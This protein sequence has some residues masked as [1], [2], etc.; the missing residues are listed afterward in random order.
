MQAKQD[1]GKQVRPPFRGSVHRVETRSYLS[2]CRS[3]GPCSMLLSL[4]TL[5]HSWPGHGGVGRLSNDSGKAAQL[6]SGSWLHP[7]GPVAVPTDVSLPFSVIVLLWAALAARRH[8]CCRKHEC[9]L[10]AD[11]T[12]VVLDLRSLS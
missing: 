1:A 5:A 2:G 7:P 3:L 8:Y 4:C 12:M 10:A 6:L 9:R 11:V